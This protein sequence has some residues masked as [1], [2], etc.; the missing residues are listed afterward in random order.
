MA[1]LVRAIGARF[2]ESHPE[3][4]VRVSTGGS[5]QGIKDARSG[6]ADIGMASRALAEDEGDLFGFPVARDAVCL[7]VHRDNPVGELTDRQAADLYA[8]RVANWRDV[9][10]RD[11][12]AHVIGR[13]PGHAEVEIFAHHLKLRPGDLRAATEAGDNDVALRAVADDPAAVAYVSLGEAE[14]A[15]RRGAPVRLLPVDG[16]AATS[17]N[18]RSGHFPMSRPLTLVTRALPEGTAKEFIDFAT[19]AQV[20]DLVREFD[21]VPY[22]D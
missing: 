14:R 5:G 3:V 7:V 1:A 2:R 18:V 17:R 4:E 9:G 10:G 8:G 12:P 15:V 22:L 16:V 19:S 13:S 6:A 20:T 21:F 11:A